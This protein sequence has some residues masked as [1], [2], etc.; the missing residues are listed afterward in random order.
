MSVFS[1]DIRNRNKYVIGTDDVV[2]CWN[3]ILATIPGTIPL[4]P[5]FGSNLFQYL[6]QPANKSFSSMANTII[7]DLERWEKRATIS[8]VHK[9]TDKETIKLMIYGIYLPT[10]KEI[11]S[12]V[13]IV[14]GATGGIG[15]MII[16]STFILR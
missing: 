5:T 1:I 11:M 10:K 15:S 7:K 8:K 4:K 14:E 12:N 13:Q 3:I 2:Q 16:G 6:D 9:I